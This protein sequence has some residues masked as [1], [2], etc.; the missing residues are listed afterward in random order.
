MTATL[1]LLSTCSILQ[2][3]LSSSEEEGD[4]AELEQ[5]RDNINVVDWCTFR[6]RNRVASKMHRS[7]MSGEV[8][9]FDP[10]LAKP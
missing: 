5:T 2:V 8:S 3:Y 10:V 4:E 6:V 1:F 7:Y 9:N